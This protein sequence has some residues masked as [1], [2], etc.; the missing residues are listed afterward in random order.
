M[1]RTHYLNTVNAPKSQ[2]KTYRKPIIS[3]RHTPANDHLRTPK[4]EGEHNI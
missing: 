1:K 3:G 2:I 4:P